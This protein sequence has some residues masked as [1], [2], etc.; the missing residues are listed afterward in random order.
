MP[1]RPSRTMPLVSSTIPAERA[2][3][4]RVVIAWAIAG[5]ALCVSLAS[6]V[7]WDGDLVA[8]VSL[9]STPIAFGVTGA[10]LAVRV[11]TNPIGSLLLV[12]T[13]GFAT[14]IAGLTWAVANGFED[15]PGVALA[16]MAADLAFIP[17]IVVILVGVSLLFPDGRWLSPRWA[18]VAV[19]SAVAVGLAELRVLFAS[20][21]LLENEAFPNPLYL[22]AIAPIL[23]AGDSLATLVAGPVFAIG[24]ACLFLRYRR[25]DPIGRLQIR[26]LVAAAGVAAACFALSFLF[27]GDVADTLETVGVIALN[28]VPVAIAIAIVRYRLYE[29]DRLISRSISYALITVIL[30]GTYAAVVLVLQGPLG[31]IIGNDT[32]VVALS[33]LIVASLFQP[34]RRRIQQGVDRRFD[35]ARVDA[36]RTAGAF[37]ARL[38][39]EVDIDAVLADLSATVDTALRP[40]RLDLWLREPD[41]GAARPT[42]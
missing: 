23:V 39:D 2:S 32:V 16:G 25:S 35:R 14:V 6:L 24:L 13:I 1:E 42:P 3:R 38:R 30:V 7:I 27:P 4:T 29:I 22:P 19:V 9:I 21:I 18:W 5:L 40:T 17:S 26:W 36:D 34:L 37:G 28:L 8:L 10:F 41:T 11:P 31:T 33:T 20:P 12:A 15:R